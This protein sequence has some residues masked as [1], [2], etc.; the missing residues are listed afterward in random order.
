VF[1]QRVVTLIAVAVKLPVINWLNDKICLLKLRLMF[2]M[3]FQCET[4]TVDRAPDKLFRAVQCSRDAV[5]S[6]S[7]LR[8]ALYDKF[9]M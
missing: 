2:E 4:E 3:A 5:L 9:D 1:T 6:K 8:R 7:K